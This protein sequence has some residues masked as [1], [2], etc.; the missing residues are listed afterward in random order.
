MAYAKKALIQDFVEYAV[1]RLGLKK[2]PR[3]QLVNHEKFAQQ[4]AALGD[5]NTRLKLIRVVTY[6]RLPAD[7]MRTLAH[8]LVHRRQHEMN[9]K[10]LHDGDDSASAPFEMKANAVAGILLR[11]Y[12]KNHKQ[13]FSK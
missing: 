6:G 1:Q 10:G 12:G 9:I 8:E 4:Y 11:D 5:Y 2:V 13:I 3:I 7:I